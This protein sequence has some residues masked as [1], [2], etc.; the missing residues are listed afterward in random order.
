M[1][2]YS[3]FRDGLFFRAVALKLRM[4]SNK[5]S[6]LPAAY[7][8]KHLLVLLLVEPARSDSLNRDCNKGLTRGK[9]GAEFHRPRKEVIID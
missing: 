3:G 4:T 7:V 1:R 5:L 8:H 6:I 9:S 2:F